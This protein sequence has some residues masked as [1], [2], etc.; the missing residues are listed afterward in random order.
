MDTAKLKKYAPQARKDFIAA[1]TDRAATYGLTSRTIEPVDQKGDVAIIGARAFPKSV[2]AKRKRLEGRIQREGFEQ[3]MEAIA[4]TWFNRL[5]ALR[6]MELHGYLDHGY[7]VLSHPDGTSTPEIVEYAEQLDLPGLDKNDVIELKLDATRESELYRLLLVAQCNALNTAMPFL[8]EWIDDET[9]LL[10]PE[11]L[12]HSDSVIRK[13]VTEIPNELWEQI[14]IIGWIYQFYISEKKDEVIGRVVESADIPAATQLFTPNWIVKYLVQNSI[15]A[16]WLE[17]YPDSPLRQQMEYYIEPAEQTLEVQAELEEIPPKELNPEELTVLDPACGSGH[18]LVEAYE[19]LKLIYLER[20]YRTKDIPRLILEKNLFGLEI[21][22]RAAQLA[23]FAVMMKAR[24]DDRR[25]FERGVQPSV[26]ALVDSTAFDAK[27]LAQSMNVADFGIQPSDLTELRQLFEHATTFGSLIQVPASLTTKLPALKRLSEVTSKDLFVADALGV[28]RLLVKQAGLLAA[29]YDT[30]AANPPYMGNKGMNP[31][32]KGFA[33][34]FFP[35]AKNDLFACF[36]ERSYTQA[37]DD[38]HSSMVTMQ[39]WM[40]LSSFEA[41]RERILR[42]KTIRTMAHL[43]ARAFGSI[44]GEVV[45]TTAFVL[46]NRTQVSY[47]PVFL[48]LLD[49]GEQEKKAA[50][51]DAGNRFD[52]TSQDEFKSIPGS[53]IAYWV[54]R[55]VRELFVRVLPLSHVAETKQGLSTSNNDLFVRAWHEVDVRRLCFDATDRTVALKTGA[56]WFPYNKGGAFRRWFGNNELVVN[57]F[58]D[59][60]EIHKYSG[61]PLEYAGAPV[62]AKQFYF[63]EGL[64]W[65][66][67]SSSDFAVRAFGSGYIFADKGQCLFPNERESTPALACFLNS[68][69]ASFLLGLLSPT[70]DY[71]CGYV[72]KLPFLRIETRT[73]DALF[74]ECLVVAK[75]DWDAYERSWDFESFPLLTATSASLRTLEAS[76]ITW[77]TRNREAIREVR[78][79]ET[80]NNRLF[81]DAYGLADELSPDVPIEQITLTV[82]PAY[83]YGGNLTEEERAIR[84]REDTMRELVSYAVGCMM[85]RYNLDEPGLIYAHSG[86]E[87]FEAARYT[88]FPADDDGIVPLTDAQ[89]FDDDACNRL[90]KFIS[91]AWNQSHL[92]ENLTFLANNLSPSKNESSRD[93]IR[94]YLCDSFF[95]AHLQ[96]YKKRPIYWLFSSGKQKAFQCLVYLHRYNEG[97]LARM[98]TEYVV[99]LQGMMSSRIEKLEGDIAGATSTSH[100]KKL[101]KERETLVKHRTELQEFDEKLRH[102]ADQRIVLD[103]DDGVKINYGKFGDLLAEVKAV[104]GANE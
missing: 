33:K 31:L 16:Q 8:F 88:G 67:L 94:R 68:G 100:R 32:V 98:R 9:E 87:G 2:A 19:L 37:K 1:V 95:K 11:H 4:Y 23:A 41:T 79:L 10:L 89:W 51:R 25:L 99:P 35:D 26:M 56:T 57:W 5:V 90:I 76:Y 96:S 29:Q 86:N 80:E 40:F 102:Y 14:E 36:I 12:L 101:E 21:D 103:L 55:R 64:T 7:R 27:R 15:G 83:R 53:P 3:V 72:A 46:R 44:S 104:T 20:G 58:G 34:N 18:I 48:R 30:V 43:G 13:L 71:H 54:S 38:G 6:Y 42:N 52:T 59:G 50:I 69:L 61:L 78:R 73:S 93:T 77:V 92:E 66:A 65:S 75:R 39:S 49:G 84:F 17:T 28:V 74:R 60:V 70:L 24:A 91:A 85:G 81:I 62:R 47:K 97:T 22:D 45:Q 82:N 63:R